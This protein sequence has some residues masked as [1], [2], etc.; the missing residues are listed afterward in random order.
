MSTNTL[1]EHEIVQD[2][3]KK[4]AKYLAAFKECNNEVQAIALEMATIIASSEATE[5]ERSLALDVFRDALFPGGAAHM[6]ERH[7]ATMQSEEGRAAR[8]A[9]L[10]QEQLFAQNVQRHM[11]ERGWTQEILAAQTGV[12]QPAISNMLKR[13][14]RP[15]NRTISTLARAFGVAEEALWPDFSSRET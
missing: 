2:E 4:I 5:D 7:S 11:D 9:V 10:D 15:Q 8:K 1:N 6:L 12:S 13:R 14:C 3:L